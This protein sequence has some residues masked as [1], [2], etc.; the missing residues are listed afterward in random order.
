[1]NKRV[2]DAKKLICS[3]GIS[4]SERNDLLVP[5]SFF[6]DILGIFKKT[7]STYTLKIFKESK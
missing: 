4:F 1:M 3:A 5:L 6:V 2:V 7:K